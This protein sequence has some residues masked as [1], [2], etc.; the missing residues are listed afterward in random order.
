MPI[1]QEPTQVV[2][3]QLADPLEF[4][5]SLSR[6]FAETQDI[7]AT[8]REALT[9][10]VRLLKVEAGA[11]FLLDEAQANLVCRAAVGPVDV[12]GLTVPTGHGIVGRAVAEDKIQVVEHAYEDQAFFAEADKKTGFVTRSILC[13]PMGVAHSVIG[14]VEVLNKQNGQPFNAEDKSLLRVMAASAALAINNARMADRLVAQERL[15]REVELAADIQRHLLPDE[16]DV[17]APISGLVRPILEVSGDFYDHFNLPDGTIAFA[18][19][20]VSGKGLNASLLMAKT[21]SLFRCLGKTV[22]DPSRLMSILN[23]EICETVSRGMFVTMIAGLYDPSSGRL[24]FANAGHLPPLVRRPGKHSTT[25]PADGP[26]LGI[27]P[28]AKFLTE[29]LDLDG[30]QFILCTDGV[31]EF[32]FGDEELGTEGLDMLFSMNRG[33]PIHQ[34]LNSVVEELERAGWRSRDDLT[35]LVIDDG[36]AAAAWER[37]AENE[38]S[39]PESSDFLFGLSFPADP[40]R[41]KLVRPAIR[42]AAEACGFD[43]METDD[44]LLAAG[45]AIENIIV[46]AYAGTRKGEI[47]LAVHRM[48]D[49]LMLR[50]RDFAPNVDPAKIAPRDLD[51]VRPG[52]LGTHFIR[53]VM[54]D[55]SFIPLPDGEGNLLELVK[56]KR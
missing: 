5:A 24:R 13:A 46:H 12:T 51:D 43:E 53:A 41:L 7:N 9:Q 26:P 17:G 21:A 11:I 6:S 35:L 28:N 30:A 4:A 23:R 52:G 8:V 3:D 27:V 29:E 22:R 56:R 2:V 15:Q 37:H 42:A 36:L 49:G 48:A 54:D 16:N 31:T 18:I 33:K 32:R 50:I 55:A 47:A 34:R 39:A 10:I 14:A 38:R 20:D 1:D 19:G 25:M 40:K 44:V 45:E